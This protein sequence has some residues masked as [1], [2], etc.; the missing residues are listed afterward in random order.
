VNQQLKTRLIDS[1]Q[2]IEALQKEVEQR[3]IERK[4]LATEATEVEF[5]DGIEVQKVAYV[6]PKITAEAALISSNQILEDAKIQANKIIDDA[7][8]EKEKIYDQVFQEAKKDGYRD[9]Y[10][11]GTLSTQLEYDEKVVE[12]EKKIKQIQEEYEEKQK[13]ME[14]LIVDT[15]LEVIEKV[16]EIQIT[17][18]REI[19]LSLIRKSILHIDNTKDF[20]IFLNRTQLDYLNENFQ[21]FQ[22]ELG[23]GKTVNCFSDDSLMD[24][25]CRIETDF[26]TYHCGFDTYFKN[27][28]KE[29]KTLSI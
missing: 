11:D 28:I 19:V 25:Q 27:L 9:G 10:R 13:Q 26:G 12:W 15:L 29:I 17:D 5:I 6:E 16:I 1:N 21:Q 18:K 8:L 24:E 20:R 22:K 2:K 23:Q 4:T 3:E 14:P 7:R